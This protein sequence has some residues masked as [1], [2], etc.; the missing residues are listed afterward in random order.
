MS[1]GHNKIRGNSPENFGKHLGGKKG[2]QATSKVC[3]Y[4]R[5]IKKVEESRVKSFESQF[6]N[7]YAC[8]TYP[9]RGICS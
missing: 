3:I 7:K 4:L 1:G 6:K 5:I 2:G 9:T 8:T